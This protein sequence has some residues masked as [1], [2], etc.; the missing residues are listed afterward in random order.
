MLILRSATNLLSINPF[1]SM[2]RNRSLAVVSLLISLSVTV[3]GNTKAFANTNAAQLYELSYD[4]ATA[5]YTLP[6]TQR[7]RALDWWVANDLI[8]KSS[9]VSEAFEGQLYD[10]R[11]RQRRVRVYGSSTRYLFGLSGDYF[12]DF[13]ENM[14]DVSVY[15]NVGNDLTIDG[16]SR[17]DF[18]I[19]LKMSRDMNASGS[20]LTVTLELPFLHRA[21]Q[22]SSS[23]EA[24]AL[25]KNNLY[26]PA[27]GVDNGEVRSS[28]ISRY[29]VPEL[30]V[31]YLLPLNFGKSKIF[32]GDKIY[33]GNKVSNGNKTLLN[34][35][36][37]ASWGVRGVTRLGWY[38]GE[39]PTPDYYRNLPSYADTP[40]QNSAMAGLWSDNDLETT[41]ISWSR[42]RQVNSQSL[43]G[44]SDYYVENQ[45]ERKF[46]TSLSA[47]FTTNMQS[48][49]VSLVYGVE[50]ETMSN[51]LY[52]KM[53]DLLGGE[54]YLD[55]DSYVGDESYTGTTLQNNLQEPNREVLEGDRFGYDYS[56]NAYSLRGVLGAKYNNG[57]FQ[58]SVIGAFGEESVWRVGHYEKERFAGDLSLGKSQRVAMTDSRL[59]V[60]LSYKFAEK[61]RGRVYANGALRLAPMES[62]DLFL[63]EQN[64]NRV[65]VEPKPQQIANVDMGYA[66]T[67]GNGDKF[68]KFG[69]V[70]ISAAV[71]YTSV[72]NQTQTWQIYDDLTYTFCDVVMSGIATDSYG[73]EFAAKWPFSRKLTLDMTLAAGR[74][75]YASA[76]IVELYNNENMNY[77]TMTTATAVEGCVIGNAPQIV[78]TATLT[79]QVNYGFNIYVNCAYAGS[80]YAAPSIFRRT[81]RVIASDISPETRAEIVSQENL[82]SVFDLSLN[83]YKSFLIRGHRLAFTARASNLLGDKNRINYGREANRVISSLAQQ[84]T[85]SYSVGRNYY[86]SCAYNF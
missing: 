18:N 71:F 31:D 3:A 24:F 45:V 57:A 49:R 15:A 22:S 5:Y 66:T 17:R 56:R 21:L 84:S 86:I 82:G 35:S 72:R 43:D 39:N 78:S 40:A 44:V 47:L 83:I 12:R 60:A 50:V 6:V 32:N 73:V 75:R 29:M 51:R 55:F 14:F 68:D 4:D 37:D 65:V 63:Q 33:N 62:R 64:A 80:R 67:L 58:C 16:L 7:R 48:E 85:Y 10:E 36:F 13:K 74:Y 54:F 69:K 11:D 1:L 26:N 70:Y 20:T 53:E 79:W 41:Q 25:T 28:R 34:V 61:N 8:G 77:M 23:A 2:L 81:E 9:S 46:E 38:E 27:W 19:E 59:N 52:K 30:K 76:P 42:L